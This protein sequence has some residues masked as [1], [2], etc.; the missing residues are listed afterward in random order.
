MIAWEESPRQF[1]MSKQLDEGKFGEDLARKFLNDPIIKVNHG[2]SHYDDVTQDKSYQDKDTDFIV[3]KKNGKT[4]GLEAKVDSHNTGNFYL[5]TS[6]DYFSMVPD[7]LNEQRVARRYRDGI[8]PLWHT[9]G[10]VYRS[11][12][13]QILYYFRTTQLLYIFSR[14]DVWFYAEKLMRGGIHLDP[15]IS[16][17]Y[18]AFVGFSRAQANARHLKIK[19]GQSYRIEDPRYAEHVKYLWLTADDNSDVKVYDQKRLVEYADYKPGMLYVS[20]YEVFPA[21]EGH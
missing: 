20:V 3:W 13:D 19:E 12:A 11:G 6:V 18:G 17:D 16:G 8:D 5:E 15:G 7:A 10:W 1:K 4:F 2:I 21:G 14:V 9:P